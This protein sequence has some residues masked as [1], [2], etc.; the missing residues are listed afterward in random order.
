M[1]ND[2]SHNFASDK[3]EEEPHGNGCKRVV[4]TKHPPGENYQ[5]PGDYKF[6]CQFDFHFDPS[7]RVFSDEMRI[8]EYSG[9]RKNKNTV[10][11][12]AGACQEKRHRCSRTP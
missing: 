6:S 9:S 12:R 11:V 2:R 1:P 5:R 3:Q 4:T 10:G 7:I 8:P